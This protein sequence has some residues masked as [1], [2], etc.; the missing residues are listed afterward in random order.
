M[1]AKVWDCYISHIY[2]VSFTNVFLI[3]FCCVQCK[4]ITPEIYICPGIWIFKFSVTSFTSKYFTIKIYCLIKVTCGYCLMK[5]ISHYPTLP[6]RLIPTSFC[7]STANSMGS[8]LNT[9]L[10]NPL[11]IKDVASSGDMP[12][13]VQ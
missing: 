3:R 2:I 8:S 10:Q 1:N 5:S 4:L 11:T 6:S 7:A 9:S 12:R 13:W